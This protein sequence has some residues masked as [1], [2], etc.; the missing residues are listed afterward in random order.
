MF[1]DTEKALRELEAELLAEEPIK[2]D[3]VSPEEQA[4]TD[5]L[6]DEELDALLEDT[7]V[8]GRAAVYR[9]H[10]NSFGNTPTAYNADRTD[11]DPQELS[12]ELENSNHGSIT[13]LLITAA[14]L[15]A[16]IVGVLI[17]LLTRYGGA[18]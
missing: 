2:P 8:I 3:E 7:H 11:L 5:L 6:S 10:S 1:K 18:F 12:E 15:S 17:Y 9:N 14:V 4:D 16:A 13:G